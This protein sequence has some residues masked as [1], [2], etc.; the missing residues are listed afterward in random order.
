MCK[1]WQKQ[2]VVLRFALHFI[3]CL[4]I[5]SVYRDFPI[6]M[7]PV[8]QQNEQRVYKTFNWR[9]VTNWRCGFSLDQLIFVT[10]VQNDFLVTL[11]CRNLS[12][13]VSKN[14]LDW[15]CKM[16]S[17]SLWFWNSCG[18]SAH[19]QSSRLPLL[20]VLLLIPFF[21]DICTFCISFQTLHVEPHR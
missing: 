3:S 21:G 10:L 4:L 8:W 7:L 15:S 18:I 12:T 9:A 6:A 2:R 11:W 14:F 17:C 5:I 13:Y 16:L 19:D 1:R 20:D